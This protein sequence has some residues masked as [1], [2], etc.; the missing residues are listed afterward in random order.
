M[1]ISISQFYVTQMINDIAQILNIALQCERHLL[2]TL[3]I[4]N[5]SQSI[6]IH[7]FNIIIFELGL[8]ILTSTQG[9][10][11]VII[12]DIDDVMIP[13]LLFDARIFNSSNLLQIDDVN[14]NTVDHNVNPIAFFD[15]S[16]RI[17]KIASTI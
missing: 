6:I 14:V 7:N 5:L 9:I 1:T 13:N 15:I 11:I 16:Y 10:S 2:L 4:Y 8:T 12:V 17:N 3:D